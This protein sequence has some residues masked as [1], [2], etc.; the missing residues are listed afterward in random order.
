[1]T[2]ANSGEIGDPCG[3]PSSLACQ[4]PSLMTPA[5]K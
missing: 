5:C 1:M 3:V 4:L 2:L